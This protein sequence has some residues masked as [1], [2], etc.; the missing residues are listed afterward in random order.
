MPLFLGLD[1]QMACY[2]H[3]NQNIISAFAP[4]KYCSQRDTIFA[5]KCGYIIPQERNAVHSL[6]ERGWREWAWEIGTDE[7]KTN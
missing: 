2:K 5:I 4:F 7:L 6:S 1:N 3:I